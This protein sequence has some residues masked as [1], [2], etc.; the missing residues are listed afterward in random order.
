MANRVDENFIK[1][2]DEGLN[3]CFD[4]M[5]KSIKKKIKR[6]SKDKS[7]KVAIENARH[8][9]FVSGLY[10]AREEMYNK[11]NLI[12]ASAC[13]LGAREAC[14]KILELIKIDFLKVDY[15]HISELE[16][17]CIETVSEIRFYYHEKY[18]E[19]NE[20]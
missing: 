10:A 8:E 17:I 12:N 20:T 13:A 15:E 1:Q 18:R 16:K 2:L 14:E 9:G 4:S 11:K 3:P 19:K 5:E 7:D 6:S